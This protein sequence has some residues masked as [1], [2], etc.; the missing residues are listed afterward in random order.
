[1]TFQLWELLAD[2]TLFDGINRKS[3]KYSREAHLAQMIRLLGPPPPQLLQRVNKD[4]HA[5]LFSDQGMVQSVM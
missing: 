3:N 5:Q 1:M 2:T 4:V